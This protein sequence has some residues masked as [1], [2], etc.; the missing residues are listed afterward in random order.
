MRVRR[1]LRLPLYT[2]GLLQQSK[3][4]AVKAA[5]FMGGRE[6]NPYCIWLR[7]LI[8][9]ATEGIGSEIKI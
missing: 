8:F 5:F 9:T 6:K 4:C 7:A 1:E 3:S 2:G